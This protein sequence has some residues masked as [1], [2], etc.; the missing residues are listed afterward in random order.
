MF[1]SNH[2]LSLL[3]VVVL[4]G[5]CSLQTSSEDDERLS[6]ISQPLPETRPVSEQFDELKEDEEPLMLQ[7][8]LNEY[9]VYES[10]ALMIYG[11]IIFH[12]HF[13][14]AVTVDGDIAAANG[15][16]AKVRQ[17]LGYAPT[18]ELAEAHLANLTG[19]FAMLMELDAK[20]CPLAA[21]A[22]GKQVLLAPCRINES[23]NIVVLSDSVRCYRHSQFFGRLAL[24][25]CS[26]GGDPFV[27]ERATSGGDGVALGLLS[28]ARCEWLNDN[29]DRFRLSM[30]NVRRRYCD[31]DPQS[32][33]DERPHKGVCEEGERLPGADPITPNVFREW[34]AAERDKNKKILPMAFQAQLPMTA[35]FETYPKPAPTPTSSSHP[36]PI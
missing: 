34:L 33:S 25:G 26:N 12:P 32:E 7:L 27:S 10:V 22:P 1:N 16:I 29:P 31:N 30:P 13:D 23:Q 19:L 14:V 18:D 5:A 2:G 6:L 9:D 20:P 35:A 11:K 15:M 28:Q 36:T 3:S 21:P 17:Y 24:F 8:T 4:T